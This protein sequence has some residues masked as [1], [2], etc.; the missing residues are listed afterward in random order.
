MK[1]AELA[2][3]PVLALGLGVDRG[4]RLRSWDRMIVP[5]PFARLRVHVGDER[6][7]GR[8]DEAS[9][10]AA[11]REVQEELDRL[12]AAASAVGD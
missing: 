10:A 12:S 11:R 8:L 6:R 3:A 4:W 1:L 7:L 5:K 9:R 2:G